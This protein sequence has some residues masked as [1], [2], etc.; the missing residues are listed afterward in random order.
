MNKKVSKQF[1]ASLQNV[2]DIKNQDV[3]EC[4]E[5]IYK[6]LFIAKFFDQKE[7]RDGISRETEVRTCI[8]KSM[9]SI[10]EAKT[11]VSDV[12]KYEIMAIPSYYNLNIYMMILELLLDYYIK[13]E[14]TLVEKIKDPIIV[15]ITCAENKVSEMVKVTAD[16]E[17]LDMK[18]LS[19]LFEK[20][21]NDI[22]KFKNYISKRD[23]AKITD[24]SNDDIDPQELYDELCDEVLV[25]QD[26]TSETDADKI[27]SLTKRA[28]DFFDGWEKSGKID[29]A[30]KFINNTSK[31]VTGI[32]E[33]GGLIAGVAGDDD[34]KE[35]FECASV[36]LGATFSV[37]ISLIG[38]AAGPIGILGVASSLIGGVT[39]IASYFINRD[40]KTPEEI[41]L[42]QIVNLGNMIQNSFESVFK[43]L[44]SI[45]KSM[46]ENFIDIKEDLS[47][48]DE[49]MSRMKKSFDRMF[50]IILDEGYFNKRNK[51]LTYHENIDIPMPIEMQIDG[52]YNFVNCATIKSTLKSKHLSDGLEECIDG[53]NEDGVDR[54]ISFLAEYVDNYIVP[55]DNFKEYV[56]PMYW[57]EGSLS[58]VEFILRTPEFKV[59]KKQQETFR[60]IIQL[61]NNISKLVEQLYEKGIIEKIIMKYI[62][63]L[64]DPFGDLN[65]ITIKSLD[66]NDILKYVNDVQSTVSDFIEKAELRKIK[67]Y[68]ILI[69]AYFN[70][71]H[72]YDYK[73][74]SDLSL[75]LD[76]LWGDNEFK[77]CLI[78]ISIDSN[79][80]YR[81]IK[82][83]Y[84]E[85]L[86][87]YGE[88]N[89]EEIVLFINNKY[90][91]GKRVQN[92]KDELKRICRQL[93]SHSKLNKKHI[94][95]LL[96]K[97]II[98][99]LY[100]F[101]NEFFNEELYRRPNYI[102]G[103]VEKDE[104]EYMF[105]DFGNILGFNSIDDFDNKEL[106][107]IG[108]VKIASEQKTLPTPWKVLDGSWHISPKQN[109]NSTNE[110]KIG[111]FD[112]IFDLKD[113]SKPLYLRV[114]SRFVNM[115]NEE[116][117]NEHMSITL[118]NEIGNYDIVKEYRPQTFIDNSCDAIYLFDG[119]T[120]KSN[121]RN[122]YFRE[123][124][125]KIPAGKLCETINKLT[126]STNADYM[127]HNIEIATDV[128]GE[129]DKMYALYSK[130]V[131][132]YMAI[133]DLKEN[134]H[135][136]SI[137]K[138]LDEKCH[139]RINS[140]MFTNFIQLYS[141]YVDDIIAPTPSDGF[142]WYMEFDLIPYK[143]LLKNAKEYKVPEIMRNTWFEVEQKHSNNIY[144]QLP[145][146]IQAYSNILV[147]YMCKR[148]TK[149]E[150]YQ[151]FA[152]N[153]NR[154]NPL[155]FELKEVKKE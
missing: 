118:S 100:R 28:N 12:G 140:M 95:Y 41:I 31:I 6:S 22:Q 15:C 69:K 60:K 153:K 120:L 119:S 33:L 23:V 3:I 98:N 35:V 114:C 7:P 63:C 141:S 67:E 26:R 2:L 27:K 102:F 97:N 151:F 9:P 91:L 154:S 130:E 20:Y 14:V 73:N 55:I 147:G 148:N 107:K 74:N 10:K 124:V 129:E 34:A 81:D 52:F 38:C 131:D 8:A 139:F 1:T 53:I 152:G 21:H 85:L 149:Q 135:R 36:I 54:Y 112:V 59:V 144:I 29:H 37:G 17:L 82:N 138:E 76:S 155:C 150:N 83:T 40:K 93:I 137:Q 103:E 4:D 71:I 24:Q 146:F 125:W 13:A 32:T 42:D 47:K 127:I 62:K 145:K 50:D 46:I 49:K 48:I 65:K 58:L 111:K 94:G 61:G 84:E 101:E 39:S 121:L 108:N 87:K 43:Y 90:G 128:L 64:D 78:N 79:R 66:N 5:F 56:S 113:T 132:G 99:F 133:E 105:L 89:T 80:W 11:S 19:D 123:D 86:K 44:N 126:F 134:K 96:G 18:E 70:L 106:G 45:E 30:K 16:E 25:I 51:V 68:S 115:H 57:G 104:L 136:I 92:V 72:N 75:A 109:D 142:Y 143:E 110:E 117:L 116:Y 77:N 122:R 88:E